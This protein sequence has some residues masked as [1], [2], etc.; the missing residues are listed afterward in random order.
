REYDAGDEAGTRRF[1]RFSYDL[2]GRTTFASYQGTSASLATGVWTEYDALG[3]VVSASQD[4]EQG[5][6]TSLTSYLAGSRVRVTNP[7]GC[8]TTTTYMAYGQPMTDWPV[9]IAHPEGAFTE[10]AR[11]EFGKPLA[12]TRRN[13]DGSLS[14]TRT[15]VYDAYGQLCKTVEPEA[16]ATVIAYDG[17]GN[18]IWSASGK[19]FPD[20]QNCNTGSVAQSDRILRSY[21]ARKRLEMLS[22]PDGR[23]DQNWA[24]TPDGL[25]ETIETANDS[26]ADVIV[27]N[28][29]YNKRRLPLGEELIL[30]GMSGWTLGY[31]YSETGALASI[32]Y[33]DGEA[34]NYDPNA[35]GQPR[36]ASGY[37]I[38]V[39]YFP[40]G[41]MQAFTYGNGIVHTM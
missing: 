15:M 25:P 34:V 31:D 14:L 4:S 8:A 20:G 40:N 39:D 12:I 38:G 10:I 11:D 13:S 23:G 30:P 36:K 5:L 35:L 17:A 6:L 27:N 32:T 26:L 37:A 3:R 21:D 9:L 33:P 28:Y 22:I 19:D 2:D 29:T 7:R 18:V 1:Q 41:G 24:Y 16:G